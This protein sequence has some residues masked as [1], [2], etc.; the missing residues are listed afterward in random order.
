M[1]ACFFALV[2]AVISNAGLNLILELSVPVLNCLY[3]A[4][5]VLIALAF[6]PRR[7]QDRPLLYPL[8]VGLA[9]VFG[10]LHAL[11]QVGLSIPGLT[12]LAGLLPLYQEGLG[13]LVPA[14]AGGVLGALLPGRKENKM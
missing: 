9:A 7:I 6:L 1:W 13:W 2:S 14:V 12:A 10:V 5:I 4:A 3:P 11:D 8:A